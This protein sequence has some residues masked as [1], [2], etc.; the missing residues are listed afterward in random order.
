MNSSISH[1]CNTLSEQYEEY[2]QDLKREK[3]KLFDE[4]KQ[5][6]LNTKQINNLKTEVQELQY[7]MQTIIF[8][9]QQ[10]N[11]EKFSY[12][13]QIEQLTVNDNIDFQIMNL[14]QKK[15]QLES[16]CKDIDR[17]FSKYN[18]EA[19]IVK[20]QIRD[21]SNLQIIM[22]DVA[23]LENE[24][25]SNDELILY[26][27]T[28]KGLENLKAEISDMEA[29]CTSLISHQAEQ[30]K[31]IGKINERFCQLK[32]ETEILLK[33]NSA[34]IVRLNRQIEDIKMNC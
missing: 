12:N 2:V 23:V 20:K 26:R 33:R 22:A 30:N 7:A 13:Q 16:D 31:E 4:E 34:I 10:C 8:E 14:E 1:L 32:L 5:I 24:S 21:D 28:K 17:M 15:K 6:N 3:K 18:Q 11:Q 27:C 25:G 19:D 29:K 9:Q